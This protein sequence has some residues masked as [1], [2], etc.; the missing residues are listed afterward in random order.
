MNPYLKNLDKLEFA[1]TLACTGRCRHCQNGDPDPSGEHLGPDEA[2]RAVREVCARFEIR[3][4]MAFGGEPL[5]F[6]ETV[7]AMLA[8]AAGRGV[9]LRQ[10]ITNGFFTKDR[11]RAAQVVRALAESGANDVLLSVDAFHQETI[12]LE[13]P[14]DFARLAL[15]A[16]IPVR[17]SPAWLVS[18]EDENPHNMRTRE[19]LRAFGPLGVP[20]GEGN[21]VFPSG[22]ALKYLRGYFPD[23]DAPSPYDEDPCGVRTLSF[24]PDGSVLGGNFRE[25]D[26]MEIIE[27]YKP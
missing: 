11:A 16:G 8:A 9:P 26:I 15:A 20:A 24:S 19:L 6:P 14:L 21:V 1:V 3:T 12:P 2:E 27:N 22:N 13:A 10:V 25:T 4:V 17:L 5:L 7:C 18:P 23:P